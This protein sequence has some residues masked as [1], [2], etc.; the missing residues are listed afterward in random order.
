MS[1]LPK[2]AGGRP[3]P[4]AAIAPAGVRAES[5]APEPITAAPLSPAFFR[6]ERRLSPSSSDSTA[7]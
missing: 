1:P 4:E 3:L 7:S 6:K 2:L 5:S